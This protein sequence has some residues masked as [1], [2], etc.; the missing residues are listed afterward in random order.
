MPLPALT[1]AEVHHIQSRKLIDDSELWHQRCGHCSKRY[2]DRLHHLTIGAPRLSRAE[3]LPFCPACAAGRQTR[4]P[5]PAVRTNRALVP[6]QVVWVD[7]LFVP[8]PSVKW[9]SRVSIVFVDDHTRYATRY[10]LPDKRAATCADALQR[11]LSTVVRPTGYR[12]G[13]L[14]TDRGTEFYGDFEQFCSDQSIRLRR[15]VP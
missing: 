11:F 3:T 7:L 8:I 12:L 5:V 4:R 1:E 15:S 14:H 6:F 2:L 13:A 9:N 10:F